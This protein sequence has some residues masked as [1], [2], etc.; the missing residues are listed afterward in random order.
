MEQEK[1]LERGMEK[2]IFEKGEFMY[3]WN[4]I[5]ERADGAACGEPTLKAKDEARFQVG[6]LMVR[7]GEKDPEKEEIPEESIEEY[8]DRY[9]IR[10]D[11]RGNIAGYELPEEIAE[12]VYRQRDAYYLKQDI[13]QAIADEAEETGKNIEVDDATV[14]L[15]IEEYRRRAD[16]NSPY[17]ATIEAS[18][19]SVLYC[20]Q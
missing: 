10:F 6:K 9:G 20:E 13:I 8:C 15:I 11:D 4:E 14:E 18:L 7:N 3:S 2:A 1:N 19:K 12:A 5:Y 17:N 16:C